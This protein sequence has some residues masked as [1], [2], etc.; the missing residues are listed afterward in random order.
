MNLQYVHDVLPAKTINHCMKNN[1]KF[2]PLP[3]KTTEY[4]KKKCKLWRGEVT[5]FQI[6]RKIISQK[7]T[8]TL[9]E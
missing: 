7:P 6:Q 3:K 5:I 2:I 9:S 1:N 4:L 8:T